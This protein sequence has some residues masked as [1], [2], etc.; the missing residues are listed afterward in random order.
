MPQ[1]P[2]IEICGFPVK[3]T[4]NLPDPPQVEFGRDS[5]PVEIKVK[6]PKIHLK[7]AGFRDT[8]CGFGPPHHIQETQV[9]NIAFVT[10]K[11]CK[12]AASSAKWKGQRERLLAVTLLPKEYWI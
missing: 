11:S 12:R 10:C 7:V 2:K 4:D 9:E 5:I 1:N 3:V 6:K 8:L